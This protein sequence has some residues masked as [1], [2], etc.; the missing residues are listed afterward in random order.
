MVLVYSYWVH[1][2]IYKCTYEVI[3]VSVTLDVYHSFVLGMCK[4]LCTS[5]FEILL[6]AINRSYPTVL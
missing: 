3:G 1:C 5:Y 2:S 6:I 4:I